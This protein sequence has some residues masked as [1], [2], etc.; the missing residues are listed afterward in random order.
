MAP[1]YTP[2]DYA[3]VLMENDVVSTNFCVI[4]APIVPDS[5][6]A[7]IEFSW[8]ALVPTPGARPELTHYDISPF[9]SAGDRNATIF[10]TCPVGAAPEDELLQAELTMYDSGT[11][12]DHDDMIAILNSAAYAVVDALN[13][14]EQSGLTPEP[15]ARWE[16]TT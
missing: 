16:G 6:F 15:P 10:L 2:A 3:E 1:S 5:R 9:A 11:G 7:S 4:F 12:S 8:S 13:C 14:T